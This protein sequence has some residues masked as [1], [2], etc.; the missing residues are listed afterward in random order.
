MQIVLS[1]F[2]NSSGQLQS[3]A[4]TGRPLREREGLEMSVLVM[5]VGYKFE[6]HQLFFLFFLFFVGFQSPSPPFEGKRRRMSL[7][8]CRLVR[9]AATLSFVFCERDKGLACK[10]GLIQQRFQCQVH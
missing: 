3:N 1:E 7:C 4:N 5:L 10:A 6:V 9:E 8:V 2:I